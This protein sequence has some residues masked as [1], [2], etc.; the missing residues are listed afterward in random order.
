VPGR[1][2]LKVGVRGKRK[3]IATRRRISFLQLSSTMPTMS[4][5]AYA[6][7]PGH[8]VQDEEPEDIS[9]DVV[10]CPSPH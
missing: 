2:A 10:R 4:K 9:K 6:V 5:F 7:I 8:F 3:N 1:G